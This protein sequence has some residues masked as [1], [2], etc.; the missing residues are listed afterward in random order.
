MLKLIISKLPNW[1]VAYL[2]LAVGAVLAEQAYS[3]RTVAGSNLV[4]DSGPARFAS[5]AQAEGLAVGPGGRIYIAD[6][7]DHR[8][9]AVLPDGTIQTFAGTGSPGFSGDGGPA[10]KAQF[11]APYGLSS[12]AAGNLYVADIGN[13]RIRRI[14]PGGT[15]NTVSGGGSIPAGLAGDGGPATL[16][17]LLAPRNVL[18]DN[19]GGFYF[20]DFE[21]NAIYYVDAQ[22]I[23]RTIATA[24]LRS[25]AGLAF[26]PRGGVLV[27]DSGN[28]LIRRLYANTISIYN[29]SPNRPTPLYSP[30]DIAF[31]QL[32]NL[33]IADDRGS[34]LVRSINGDIVSIA[35]GGRALA[36]D[37]KNNL[38]VASGGLVRMVAVADAKNN[39]AVSFLAG[40]GG[41]GF[42]GDEGQAVDARLN[43]PS[44]VAED[45]SGNIYIADERNHRVRRISQ[46]GVISTFAGFGLPGYSGDG[47]LAT[48]ARL[49][50]P[51]AVVAD[52]FGYVYVAEA[53]NHTVRKINP[54]GFISTIAG[55]GNAGYR[56]DGAAAEGSRLHEPSALALNAKGELYI[57][58][59][60]NGA[61]RK[62]NT[63][64][65]I[66]TEAR[67]LASPAAITFD[68]NGS[69]LIAE[70]G[71]DRVMKLE[72]NGRLSVAAAAENPQ[73]LVANKDGSITV[74]EPGRHRIVRI[75]V[76]GFSVIAGNGSGGLAGD[77]GPA[78][79]A[80]LNAP[81]ALWPTS[82]GGLLVADTA[83]HRIRKLAVTASLV[84]DLAAAPFVIL[85]AALNREGAL[86]P[87]EL[88]TVFSVE[89]LKAPSLWID[90]LEA[91]ILYQSAN[92]INAIVPQAVAPKQAVSFELRDNGQV[93]QRQVEVAASAPALFSVVVNAD[94]KINDAEHPA[95]RA[96]LT[97]AFASGIGK[98]GGLSLSLGGRELPLS[99]DPETSNGVTVILFRVP[100][101]YL[102]GGKQ[103]LT[104]SAGEATSEGL[105][106]WIE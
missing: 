46:L 72:E 15:I 1:L 88:I 45:A 57:A 43:E 27:A 12:D 78:Q 82:D 70:S 14:A 23:I 11:R 104:L 51:R 30:T 24:P 56:G 90:G 99:A 21:A 22:G 6:A 97:K 75:A 25:P 36:V 96:G 67:G 85:K 35:A 31:D 66:S 91:T 73:G 5:L 8:I 83:N 40:N 28:N 59:A 87:G 13:K 34:T 84:A 29:H 26:D 81:T 48:E 62:I 49:N 38:Y 18:V 33:S 68:S 101:G 94:G 50:R 2:V 80:Q 92:Q 103:R 106:V 39:R 16:V 32:G 47:G 52:R 55:D 53:G 37:L 4:G 58:D 64:G 17:N 20:S 102:A 19:L 95:M 10:I 41:Y 61:V 60:G 93:K 7:G 44:G 54:S 74:T 105:D 86:A 65:Q 71:G 98:S 63:L 3:I 100:S 89:A 77:G 69:L 76:D 9:R 79:L 42:S